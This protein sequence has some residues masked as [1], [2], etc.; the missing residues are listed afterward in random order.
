MIEGTQKIAWELRL[1]LAINLDQSRDRIVT[2]SSR[3]PGTFRQTSPGQEQHTSVVTEFRN[4]RNSQ[5][6]A[7]A[8]LSPDDL[9]LLAEQVERLKQHLD[10]LPEVD[11]TRV[12]QIYNRI[13]AGSYQVDADRLAEKLTAMES[14]LDKP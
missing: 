9:Q 5:A 7:E 4:K 6:E 11:A 3:N 14:A 2:V 1:R 8:R 10:E 13:Q 12:I